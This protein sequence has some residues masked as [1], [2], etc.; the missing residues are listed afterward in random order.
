MEK[1]I[2][3]PNYPSLSLKEA[4]EK[5][6]ALYKVNQ[7]HPAPREVVAKG[8]GYN[9]LN[10]ASATA[11]SALNKYG[12]LE[13]RG[14]DLRISERAMSILHPHSAAER[15]AAIRAAAGEPQLFAEL[16]EKFAGGVT[17]DELLKNYLLRSGF[18]IGAVTGVIQAYRE[19]L[20][21]VKQE[22]G[23]YDLPSSGW[24]RAPPM[25]PVLRAPSPARGRQDVENA[26]VFDEM[27]T[28][29]HFDFPNGGRVE[30]RVSQSVNASLALKL[31]E[32]QLPGVIETT[33][34]V[35]D[36]WGSGVND[37]SAEKRRTVGEKDDSD[38]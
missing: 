36:S 19:T 9:S 32:K 6:G 1:R 5:I 3:S 10:G 21:F 7:S 12:L 33:E 16:A 23:D 28:L 11:I 15:A 18:A 8:M 27:R 13:G 26:P 30:I 34:F 35:A 25:E 38:A 4:I 31:I 2:R 17:N 37:A 29:Y 20:D 22:A 24:K 14:D